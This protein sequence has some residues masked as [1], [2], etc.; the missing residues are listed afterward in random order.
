MMKLIATTLFLGLFPFLL[1]GQTL[2]A[3]AARWDDNL[4]EWNIF[5]DDDDEAQGQL[6]VRWG[7]EGREWDYRIDEY[8]GS[9][10]QRWRED[11]TQWEMRGD[12][13]IITARTIW[14]DNL[15]EWRLTDNDITL[16]LKPRWGTFA[17]EW[18]I[19]EEKYGKFEMYTEYEFDPR[20]WVIID[21]LD[22]DISLNMKMAIVFLVVYHSIRE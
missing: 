3:I 13:E 12:N 7:R 8:I 17:N 15:T 20:D 18:V 22:E 6:E 5:T 10:E 1:I 4:T 21:E 11:P 14:F 16:T 9:I 2:T 19:E